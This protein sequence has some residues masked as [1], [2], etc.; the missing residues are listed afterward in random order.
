MSGGHWDYQGAQM[1]DAME[2]IAR[3]A[4]VKERWPLIHKIFEVLGP[5]LYDIDYDM[6]WDVSG[7]TLIKDDSQFDRESFMKIFDAMKRIHDLSETQVPKV[8]ESIES[9]RAGFGL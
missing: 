8:S 7:D 5:I 9:Y 4:T 3:D 1:R 2:V 6:D